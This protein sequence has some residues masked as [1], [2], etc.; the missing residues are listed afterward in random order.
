M[1]VLSKIFEAIKGFFSALVSG[2]SGLSELPEGTRLMYT[3]VA[4]WVFIFLALFVLLRAI[5]SL[6]RTKNSA[7]VFAYFNVD[8]GISTPITHWENVVGRSKSCDLVVDDPAV[9]RSQGTLTRDDKDR[10]RFRDLGSRNGT[11]INGRKLKKGAECVLEPG[12]EIEMGDSLCTLFPI[13]LE[14][15]RNNYDMRREDTVIRS[16][17][18]ALAALTLF[19]V[20][21]MIQLRFSLGESYTDG[22]SFSFIGLAVLMWVYVLVMRVLRRRGFE[23]E[24][25]AFFLSTL[26]LAVTAS[27]FPGSTLKQ[28]IAIAMGVVLFVFMCTIL[29]NLERA[30]ALRSF[31]YI[32]SAVLLIANLLIGTTKFGAN[33]WIT[34]GGISVQPSELVKLAF[35]WAGAT[36]LDE[37][38]DRRDSLIFMLFAGF[39]F[40]CLALMGDFGTALIFFVTFLVISFLRSGDFTKLILIVGLAFVGG[41]M[42]LR[43]KSYVAARFGVWGHVWDD[44]DNMG[45][46]QTRT[47]SAA[48]SGGLVGVGA[49][50]G[51]LKNIPASETDLVFGFVTEEWGLIIA[52]MA[53]VAIVTLSVF[54]VRS[55][56]AGRSTYYTIAACSAM[57]LFLFQTTLNVFG[58]VD[59]LPLTGVT[60]PFLSAGGTSMLASWGML[61]FLK[62]ADTRLDASI[63][64]ASK[65]RDVR[66]ASRRHRREE[67]RSRAIAPELREDTD[68]E[69]TDFD[70]L[71]E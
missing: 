18:P 23:M 10:W 45:F 43:F 65:D 31:M 54:A 50:D 57:T 34:I 48:A 41:V 49:G 38:M 64:V 44:P 70:D 36:S 4:R 52:V 66:R 32:A 21:A 39:C 26:S 55:I 25:I 27:K 5:G 47:M 53:I 46:Q 20:M 22:I 42:V 3:A 62:A 8:G 61:A 33:N 51:W 16:P 9:S 13:S 63:A 69:V 17:I 1:E 58:S 60:F 30:K 67:E 6:L 56:W 59:L 37:L 40:V 28:F 12:D 71:L 14:E 15:R 19:Q 11:Y 2:V 7:E 29:R 68:V 24:T 35:I